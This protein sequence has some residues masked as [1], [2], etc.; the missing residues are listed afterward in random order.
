ML[1]RFRRWRKARAQ[2]QR[3]EAAYFFGFDRC[4]TCGH[5]HGM[6]PDC[7]VCLEAAEN[8]ARCIAQAG[9]TTAELHANLVAIA[10]CGV[11]AT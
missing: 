3:D 8:M 6:N 10:R 7:A 1:A 5:A 2:A 9:I 11:D 4:D